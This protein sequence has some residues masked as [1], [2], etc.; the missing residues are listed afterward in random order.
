MQVDFRSAGWASLSSSMSCTRFG[1][2]PRFPCRESH[3]THPPS[4]PTRWFGVRGLRCAEM[5]NNGNV[6][7]HENPLM[8][9]FQPHPPGWNRPIGPVDPQSA[10]AEPDAAIWALPATR[11]LIIILNFNGI[12]DTLACLDSLRAQTCQ[13]FDVLVIDNGSRNDD[14]GRITTHFKAEII[15]LPGNLGW[16]GGN[17]VGI[18]LA[19]DR[20]F[21]FACL[22]NND[23]VLE[24][25]ALAE[26][27]AAAR[28]IAQP[29]LLHPA[30][31]F[32]DDP[33]RWQLYP[34]P[35]PSSN[36]VIQRLQAVHDIV[37]MQWAYGACLLLP[38][39]VL[40]QVG[41][42]DERF[43]LQ[44]EENDYFRRAAAQGIPSFCARRARILHKESV[45][46]GGRVTETKVYYQVRN[47]FLLAEKHTP[48]LRGFLGAARVIL[49]SLRHQA[50]ASDARIATWLGFLSW[51]ISAN[52]LA[53][54]AREGVGDYA[55]RRFG[56]RPLVRRVVQ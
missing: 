32:F 10:A 38:A 43:F 42:L 12:A 29:C 16:A 51:L 6:I 28:L 47:S 20:G 4:A 31:A 5:V 34:R 33:S 55:R 17:N 41:L 19:L 11:V 23:T 15:A 49:W 14:L 40:Q 56:Q 8:V 13:C 9:L 22:L 7:E 53:R 46:F 3:R 39:A 35:L 50:Q 36:K 45:S 2:V 25:T 1:G 48:T 44:L 30:I 54:A 37:E 21:D 52:P 24:P 27:L 26:L 18:R